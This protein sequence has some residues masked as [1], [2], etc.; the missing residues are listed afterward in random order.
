MS[1][2]PCLNCG[3]NMTNDDKYCSHCGQS[4]K[5]VTLSVSKI[6]GDGFSTLFNWDSRL[7][8]TLRDIYKPYKLTNTYVE[9]KRKYYVNPA[10]LFIFTLLTFFSI[11][12]LTSGKEVNLDLPDNFQNMSARINL[13][14]KY[15]SLSARILPEDLEIERDS[16]KREL[17]GKVTSEEDTIEFDMPFLNVDLGSYRIKTRDIYILPINEV[18]EK[19]KIEKFTEKLILKQFVHFYKDASGGAKFVIKNFSYAVFLLVIFGAILLKILYFRNAY[20]YVE[21]LVLLFYS[22]AFA[23]IILIP[24]QLAVWLEYQEILIFSVVFTLLFLVQFFSLKKY[25][26]QGWIKTII[27]LFIFNFGYFMILGTCILIISIISAALF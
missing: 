2:R 5:E 17:F 6:L 9:G 1:D 18:I 15:D 12:F 24:V 19:Y 25:Y 3:F 23:F 27:K 7:F 10:R 14:S 11:F 20:Y 13:S 26:K 8:H 21:H 4:V 22:H 16:L